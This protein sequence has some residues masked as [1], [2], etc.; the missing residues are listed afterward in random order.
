MEHGRREEA[1]K[2]PPRR[3]PKPKRRGGAGR[4]VKRFLFVLMTL[5]LIGVC[6]SAMMAWIFM[7]YAETTLTPVLQVNA[8][9]Y[10]MNYSSFIYYQ[11]KA[12]GEWVEYQTIHGTENRIWVDIEDMPD[13]LWQAAVAIEDQRFFEHNGVDWK[14]T[15]GAAVNLVTDTKDTFGGSTITQQVLKNMTKDNDGTVNRKVRE[16]FRALEFEK[17]YTKWDILELY[18]NFIYLGQGCYGVQTAAQ[19]YF[20][21]DVSELDVAECAS[22]IAIT[23]NPSMYGPMYDITITR[24]DGTT[25]TPRELNKERQEN[26]LNKMA[27]VKG[28]ATMKDDLSD[29]ESWSTYLTEEQAQAAK[30]EVLQFT[31]GSTSA[32]DVVAEATGE[33]MYNSWFVDQVIRDV[34]ADLVEEKGISTKEAETLLYNG[35]YHIYTTLDPEIQSIAESV[36]EDRGSL[37]NL[38]SASGQLIHSGITII[39]PYTGNIVAMVGDMGPKEGNLLW[40]YAT[41]IQQP[42]SSI[43]PLTAYAPALDSGAINP[44]TTFDNYPVQLMNGSPW[45]KNSPNTYT[46]WT[47][48][49]MG[50]QKSI[51]TIAVQAL[52]KGGVTNAYAFATEKLGLSLSPEDMDVSPLGLGGLTYGLSTVE[53]AAAYASFANSGIYNEP[54]TYLK[55]L[56]EDN[57]TVILENTGEQHVAMKESTAYLMT[58]MLQKAVSNGTGGAA[59]FSGMSIAG[60]TGTTNDNFDRYFVGYTPYYVAAVWVGY[61][62][63]ER[64]SYSV[65][66]AASLWK[67]VMQQVHADLENKS[68]AKPSTGLTTVTI[69]A[70]SGLLCTDACHADPRGDRAVQVTVATGTEPKEEC[71]LHKLVNICTEGNCLAGEFCPETSVVQ[72]GYLDY[73]REDYGESIKA[74]DDAYLISSLEKAAE[75]SGGCPVHTTAAVVPE[76]P[77]VPVDPNDPDAPFIDDDPNNPANQPPD[78]S[79][80]GT[81]GSQEEWWAN[82]IGPAPTN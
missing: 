16:I 48:V 34:T 29:P 28:P 18:L 4:I 37:N 40:N 33:S 41:D 46:G 50:I 70:D 54:K 65:N 63:N 8:D 32:D 62:E 51:N 53:M 22:L 23:N 71:T 75:E 64:I 58:T 19:F 3:E 36:Y 81:G 2:T 9:D 31:D 78:S 44:G 27:E 38:T 56:G 43:K 6:T 14:R 10:T 7:K 39:D 82:I 79:G 17:N 57:S 20:G 26:I 15:L 49:S 42:G 59:R 21:K 11:D 60:K 5:V 47:S 77:N 35:G 68:F 13:A 66:P 1:P 80:G 30:D 61:K 52:Q 69:C 12:S 25:T 74:D 76:D 72:K 67:Q 73:V 55:V 24:E 45:P